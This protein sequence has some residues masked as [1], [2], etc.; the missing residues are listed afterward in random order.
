MCF[1]TMQ[2]GKYIE[3]L[4]VG[5]YDDEPASFEKMAQFAKDNGLE[6]KVSSH[7]ELYLNNAGR[8][9]TNKLKTILRYSVR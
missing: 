4:H 1:D 7:R 6:R 2:D 9:E 8:V 3:V 5:S